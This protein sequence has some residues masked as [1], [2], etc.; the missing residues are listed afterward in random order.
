MQ[1]SD[2]ELFPVVDAQDQIIGQ[3]T[4]KQCH[5]DRSLIHRSVHIV[6]RNAQGEVFFQKRSMRKDV[7]PGQWTLSATGH[8]DL[9]ETYEQAA[10]RELQEEL[11]IKTSLRPLGTFLLDYP[12]EREFTRVFVGRHEGPFTMPPEEISEGR[13]AHWETMSALH[14]SHELKLAQ[15]AI[16]LMVLV[17]ESLNA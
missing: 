15:P 12:R 7:S 5:A 3:A 17:G 6:I 4:R 2:S 9:G 13:F 1:I 8:V 16:D 10:V 14:L 11:G